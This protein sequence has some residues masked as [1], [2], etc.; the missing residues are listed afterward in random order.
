MREPLSCPASAQPGD[1]L[2]QVALVLQEVDEN[3]VLAALAVSGGC[4]PRRDLVAETRG[5]LGLVVSRLEVGGDQIGLQRAARPADARAFE[6]ARPW[7]D[8]RPTV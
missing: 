5:R 2:L 8:K 7:A 4:M 6:Q 1:R 3:A